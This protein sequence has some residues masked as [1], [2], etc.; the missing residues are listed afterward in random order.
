MLVPL[1]WLREFTPY[2]GTAEELGDR[3]TMRGLE[4]E[5]IINPFAAIS[6]ILVGYVAH[7][8]PHPNSDHLHCCKVDLGDGNM[9]DIV[10]GAP[11]VAAG[12][13]V[14]VAPVGCKLPDGT[15]IKKAKLRGEPSC[16]MICSEREL[17]LSDDHGGILILPDSVDV[18][19]RLVDALNMDT[20]VL[21]ISVTPNRSDC[22]SIL[23]IARETAQAWNLPLHVPE[24]PLIMSEPDIT[25][26]I[27]ITDPELCWLYAGHVISG[28]SVK[29]SPLR[30][31][32]RLIAVGV[33]PVSNIVDVTNYVLMECGQPL[34]SFDLDKLQGREIR[35]RTA[36]AGEEFVT[37]DGKSRV[38]TQ[39]DLCIC[40]AERP[41]ALAGVMGGLNTEI[42]AESK[43]VFL[44][45]AVFRP[46]TIRRTSRRLG[47]SSE[48]SYRFERGIDQQRSIWALNR[49]S[50][51]IA[52]LGGGLAKKGLSLAEPKPFRPCKIRFRPSFSE[53]VL[54]VTMEDGFQE[55][56]LSSLGCAVEKE[57]AKEWIVAQPS[58]RPDLTREA[59]L[60]EEVGRVYGLDRIPPTLPAVKRSADDD[61]SQDSEFA[62]RQ[63]IKHWGA[64]LGLNEV[65]NYSFV[66]QEDLNRLGLPMENRIAVFNPLSEEQNVLRTSL[67]PG[68]LQDLSNNLAYDVQSVKLFELAVAFSADR[69]EETGVHEQS[70]LGILL[71][72]LSHNAGWPHHE[73]N[74]DYTDMNGLLENLFN[75]LHLEKVA[76]KPYADHAFLLPC[77]DILLEG[78]SAGFMGR[79]K[80]A[81]AD[82]YNAKKDVWLAELD[83]EYLR[84][85]NKKAKR[86]FKALPV[87]PA[88]KRDMT[89]SAR[90]DLKIDEILEKM[91]ALKMPFLE[92][93]ALIDCYVPQSAGERNLTFRLTFRHPDRTL[94]DGEVDKEREKLAE[95]LKKELDVKI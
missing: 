22:L 80:P 75:F 51:L 89:I 27:T 62:F 43:N 41:I 32:Y 64:G 93:A 6:E 39:D 19:H 59:D 86:S 28:V 85:L 37:L 88:V 42:D 83:L 67:V 33:R 68:L 87:Y 95:F 92:G 55:K 15:V 94:K 76:Y 9:V 79:V 48:A 38:L 12:Q 65:I 31:R 46:Q 11:N 60:V 54:G 7:C 44:E 56:T 52:S 10:C 71:Y 13:K 40:D 8:E 70:L 82:A 20:E 53:K 5:E 69:N 36:N 26:P 14:A 2:E 63:S 3:L 4:L 18:G 77:V 72:G 73:R 45:S 78:K 90:E 34:H 84:I 24:L 49:A 57:S 74:L 91:F 35:V 47:L 61:L 25:L 23:G 29:P 30:F 21:D 66:G 81:I 16:G 58:W 50:S 17:G 1:A